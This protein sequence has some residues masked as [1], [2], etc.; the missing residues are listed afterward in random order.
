MKYWVFSKLNFYVT[1]SLTLPLDLDTYTR[2][3]F[4][5]HSMLTDR[6]TEVAKTTFLGSGDHTADIFTLHRYFGSYTNS[7]QIKQST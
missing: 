4:Y 6:Q 5:N 7:P 3:A 1:F 2:T